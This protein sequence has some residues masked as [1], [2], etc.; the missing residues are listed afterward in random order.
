MLAIQG[1]D[2]VLNGVYGSYMAKVNNLV[3][4]IYFQNADTYTGK[5]AMQTYLRSAI[6]ENQTNTQ[7]VEEGIELVETNQGYVSDISD[8]L[9]QMKTLA[10]NAASGSYS[11]SEV[12]DMQ[13]Q[14]EALAEEIDDIAQGPLGETHILTEDNRTESVFIGSGLSI[15]IDTHDM[16]T[17]S[18]LGIGSV[19]LTADAAAAVTAIGEAISEVEDYAVHL[20]TKQISLETSA[21]AL[22]LQSKSLLAVES[23]VESTN[24][25]LMVAGMINA[26]ATTMTN[27]LMLAQANTMADT[28]LQLLAD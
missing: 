25:A 1:Y 19:D 20:D 28:V 4:T 6:A 7:N 5:S 27:Y 16:D 23:A 3:S 14:F 12:A 24:S 26:E 15:Q 11:A 21:A 8:K 22:E 2:S 13:T 9:D 18:G 17:T 10:D